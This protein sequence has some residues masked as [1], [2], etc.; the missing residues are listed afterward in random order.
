[1]DN[2]SRNSGLSTI[3][4]V[5]KL[6]KKIAIS[7][8]FFPHIIRH[9]AANPQTSSCPFK[10][11]FHCRPSYPMRYLSYWRAC[12]HAIN[13][14]R[15]QY[16]YLFKI[17]VLRCVFKGNNLHGR[18]AIV[19]KA[20]CG[21][22]MCAQ[23]LILNKLL[24][25]LEIVACCSSKPTVILEWQTNESCCNFPSL[26]FKR[27]QSYIQSSWNSIILLF[28]LGHISKTHYP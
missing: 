25:V 21:L 17:R 11:L 23:F 20:Y 1:M 4:Y 16:Q 6:K 7:F 19:Q 8:S 5:R 28:N 9:Y 12:L 24:Q 18:D 26:L 22:G 3:K 15:C 13:Q 14:H 2:H 10:L 27:Q